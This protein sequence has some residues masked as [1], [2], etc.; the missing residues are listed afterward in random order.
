M[1]S[2]IRSVQSKL[3][4]LKSFINRY[5]PAIIAGLFVIGIGV[6]FYAV[7]FNQF[8]P[9]KETVKTEVKHLPNEIKQ[10]LKEASPS[11]A[12]RVPILFYHYVE[13]VQ[14]RKDTI[15]QSLD[16]LPRTFEAQIKTLSD[17]G[18]IFLTAGDLADILDGLKP[19]PSK[20]IL[21]TFDDGH[22]DLATDVL[23]VITK[24]HV[25]VTAY[26]IS[27][28]IGR[29]DFLSPDQLKTVIK[30]GLVEIGSHTVHHVALAKK[31]PL[32]VTDEVTK[33][34]ADL[35]KKYG[36]NI[37]SFAY[38]DGSFDQ[39]AIDAVK[40]A[41]YRTAVSTV[42]GIVQSQ[43]NRYFLYRLRPGGRTGKVLLTYLE[44]TAFKPW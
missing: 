20:P 22:W 32:T 38:P 19:M 40:A 1:K 30:S 43:A 33:S 27:G 13:V 24:Y 25:H 44:Q 29:S 16:I 10:T 26:I 42:P 6:G 4:E 15:R 23:P 28:F 9:V 18:Y 37:V 21:L 8:R 31:L 34:K 36:L 5:W 39:Q 12:I 35:E 41:G 11:A 14:D 2:K 7:R 3:P 17:A